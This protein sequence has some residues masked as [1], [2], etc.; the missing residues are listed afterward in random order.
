MNKSLAFF[1][2]QELIENLCVFYAQRKHVLIVGAEG[3][4]KTALLRQVNQRCPMLLC[5][6]SA[7][8]N[9]TA[10]AASFSLRIFYSWLWCLLVY[11]Q[12]AHRDPVR[13][14]DFRRDRL[15]HP[16]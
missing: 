2:R 7:S 12:R 6:E 5:E 11:R 13:S 16:G 9:G 1:G 3:I 15:L 4:G 10:G 14:V 8:N